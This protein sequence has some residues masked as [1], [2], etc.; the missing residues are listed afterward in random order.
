[1]HLY[2]ITLYFIYIYMKYKV[3]S[4]PFNLKISGPP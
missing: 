3:I 4:T 2:E 1:M